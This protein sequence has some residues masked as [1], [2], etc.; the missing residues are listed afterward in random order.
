MSITTSHDRSKK[1]TMHYVLVL[2]ADYSEMFEEDGE[3]SERLASHQFN[4]F[5]VLDR[6]NGTKLFHAVC[7][8]DDRIGSAFNKILDVCLRCDIKAVCLPGSSS[9]NDPEFYVSLHENFCTNGIDVTVLFRI[10][11]STTNTDMVHSI[12]LR[13]AREQGR[14]RHRR[15]PSIHWNSTARRRLNFDT[16][17]E[18]MEE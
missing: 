13:R 5:S 17:T 14:I 15:T 12:N 10:D 4:E 2:K 3:L 18:Q 1:E 11:E 8:G 7:D 6:H 9:S 16:I